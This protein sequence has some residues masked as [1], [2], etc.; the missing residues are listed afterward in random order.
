[1]KIPRAPPL[2][3]LLRSLK[4]LPAYCNVPGRIVESMHG[5]TS[6]YMDILMNFISINKY[7]VL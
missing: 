6:E 1:M 4:E 7:K 3:D 5:H 2:S